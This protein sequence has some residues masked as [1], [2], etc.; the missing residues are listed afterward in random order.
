MTNHIKSANS[1][2][3]EIVFRLPLPARFLARG[4]F[5]DFKPEAG[6]STTFQVAGKNF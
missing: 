2:N 4:M 1:Q 6:L 5:L 3:P